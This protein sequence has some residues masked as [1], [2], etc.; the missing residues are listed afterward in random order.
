MVAVLAEEIVNQPAV[1]DLVVVLD[2][3]LVLVVPVNQVFHSLVYTQELIMETLVRHIQDH[4]LM[5][6]VEE[7]VLEVLHLRDLH[8]DQVELVE[9]YHHPISQEFLLVDN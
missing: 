9:P 2:I 3:M 8:V 5:H 1:V 4:L 6:V 7:E